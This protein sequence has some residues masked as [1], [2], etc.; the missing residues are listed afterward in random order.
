MGNNWTC[1]PYTYQS[2]HIINAKFSYDRL[3]VIISNLKSETTMRKLNICNLLTDWTTMYEANSGKS[4]Q[5]FWCK[6]V[7]ST[8]I[9]E[10][11]FS[12]PERSFIYL[13]RSVLLILGFLVFRHNATRK[14]IPFFQCVGTGARLLIHQHWEIM[15]VFYIF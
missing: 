4:L 12:Y 3:T 8:L 10:L 13:F 6:N 15:F 5:S 1:L 14:V 11:F 7:W 2:Y 9:T